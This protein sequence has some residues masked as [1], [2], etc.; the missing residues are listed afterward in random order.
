MKILPIFLMMSGILMTLSG[1]TTTAQ[2]QLRESVCKDCFGEKE[3]YRDG[4]WIEEV[5][6]G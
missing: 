6:H 3:F 5:S 1:C 4:I 2:S